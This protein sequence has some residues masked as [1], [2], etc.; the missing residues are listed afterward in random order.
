[1]VRDDG[2]AAVAEE[3]LE[4]VVAQVALDELGARRHVLAPAGRKVV[5]H[6]DAVTVGQGALGEVAA[7]EAGAAGD[8]EGLGHA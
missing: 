6:D 8:E 1:M 7:Y 4:P 3:L 5:E 2:D